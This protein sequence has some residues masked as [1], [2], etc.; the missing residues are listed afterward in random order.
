MPTP[1]A[2]DSGRLRFRTTSNLT[3]E[4]SGRFRVRLSTTLTPDDSENSSPDDN[5]LVGRLVVPIL[6]E[7]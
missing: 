3:P 6:T 7:S 4:D 1:D 2:S 5:D